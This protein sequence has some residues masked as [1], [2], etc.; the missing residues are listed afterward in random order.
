MAE[1]AE[2]KLAALRDRFAASLT[3]RIDEIESAWAR[4]AKDATGRALGEVVAKA[5]KLAG[6]AGTFGF[7]AVGAVANR[8]NILA[9]MAAERSAPG[10][11][12]QDEI[13]SLV[14]ALKP[15]IGGALPPALAEAAETEAG[16]SSPKPALFAGATRNGVVHILLEDASVAHFLSEQLGYYGLKPRLFLDAHSFDAAFATLTPDVLIV[17]P[18][19]NGGDFDGLAA[20]RRAKALPVPPLVLAVTAWDDFQ[21]RIEAVRAGMDG[22]F[23]KPVDIKALAA[24]IQSFLAPEAD[25]PPR[26]L[27]VDDDP[28]L[29]LYFSAVLEGARMVTRYVQDPTTALTAIREFAPHTLLMDVHMPV[30]TG[31]ELA[32]VI[33]QHPALADIPIV[34]MT[35]DKSET[36]REKTLQA[37]G[38][39]FLIK[40]VDQSLL[41]SSVL[42]RARRTQGVRALITRDSMTGMLNHSNILS[43]LDAE[44]A[45]ARRQNAPLVAVMTDIDKFKL[46]NDTYGHGVGDHVIETLASLLA[47]RLRRTDILGRYGGEEFLLVLP[48]IPIHEA[49]KIMNSIREDFGRL[50]FRAGDKEFKV[51]FS[52]GLAAY[53]DPALD[54]AGAETLA[55]AADEGLYEAKRSGR[56]RIVVARPQ[57]V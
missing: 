24:A 34:F 45:R 9:A 6:S 52:C 55:N 50:V 57:K 39:D 17:D 19:T 7:A 54:K 43:A 10:G 48:G 16:L 44:M 22:Y 8:I 47:R 13:A 4:A 35:G 51:T 42:A 30:C 31:I 5:H 49:E 41:V 27:I 37:G 26:V 28:S 36:V 2:Q 25:D 23:L 1:V 56:N 12:W 11:G 46:V 33:R 14:G 32:R 18:A 40:P 53:P 21:A 38:D 3:E 20:A 29:G 15:A